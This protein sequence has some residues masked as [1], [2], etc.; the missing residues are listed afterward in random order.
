MTNTALVFFQMDCVHD[1]MNKRRHDEGGGTDEQQARKE[2]IR[3]SKQL[4]SMRRDRINRPHAAENHR[5]VYER[6]YPRQVTKV[7]VAQNSDPEGNPYRHGRQSEESK[8]SPEKA[9]TGQERIGSVFKH[10]RYRNFPP[11]LR[12][13]G[14]TT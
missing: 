11:R 8:D 3:R 2:G 9:V 4:A 6:V 10:A 7:V 1:A 5:G 12:Q 14:E 13:P